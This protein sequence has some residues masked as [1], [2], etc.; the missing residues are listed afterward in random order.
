M[1][2]LPGGP[3]S[4]VSMMTP[5]EPG[6]K[7]I[8]VQPGHAGQGSGCWGFLGRTGCWSVCSCCPRSSGGG[9]A[10]GLGSGGGVSSGRDGSVGTSASCVGFSGACGAFP[11]G[12]G[13]G[14]SEGASAEHLESGKKYTVKTSR[15]AAQPQPPVDLKVC[16]GAAPGVAAAATALRR[17]QKGSQRSVAQPACSSAGAGCQAGSH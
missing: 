16:S 17:E 1:P 8:P 3:A 15:L 5:V 2:I 12:G 10:L 13:G 4:P 14:A 6:K 9:E 7:G 11:R